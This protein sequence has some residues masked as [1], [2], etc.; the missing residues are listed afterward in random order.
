MQY[1]LI[2]VGGGILGLLCAYEMASSD[3]KIALFD[4]QIG[5]LCNTWLLSVL[6]KTLQFFPSVDLY[7]IVVESLKLLYCSIIKKMI[8][9]DERREPWINNCA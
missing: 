1:D 9:D 6:V 4:K 8:L 7:P 5:K 2:I 3:L